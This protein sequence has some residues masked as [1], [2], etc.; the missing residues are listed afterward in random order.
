MKNRKSNFRYFEQNDWVFEQN[1]WDFERNLFWKYLYENLKK[2]II[3][4]Q[5][6]K[7]EWKA[8]SWWVSACLCGWVSVR[9]W[10]SNWVNEWISEWV[11]EWVSKNEW[12]SVSDWLSEW[13]SECEW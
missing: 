12:V 6:I 2:G 13:V 9:G 8:M 1:D 3:E 4:N 5:S 11:S 10:V 7:N